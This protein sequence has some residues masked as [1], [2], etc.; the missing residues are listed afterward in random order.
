MVR[1]SKEIM[2][3]AK[4]DP[5][6]NEKQLEELKLTIYDTLNIAFSNALT[7]FAPEIEARP[8]ITEDAF[9]KARN[10]LLK[11]EMEKAGYLKSDGTVNPDYKPAEEKKRNG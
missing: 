11:E 7:M 10:D 6:L 2:E 3:V 4:K 5:K 1:K 9:L 8:D